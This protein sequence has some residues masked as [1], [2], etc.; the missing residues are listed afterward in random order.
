MKVKTSDL[1]GEAL[2][3]AVTL[4]D[5]GN[6]SIIM[7]HFGTF[8][9]YYRH[10]QHGSIVYPNYLNWS[11]AGP[12][13]EREITRMFKNLADGWTAQIRHEKEHP[14]LVGRKVTTGWTNA[15]GP[16]LLIATMRCFVQSRLGDEVEIPEE[17]MK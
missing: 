14:S 9:T 8:H 1:E 13:I 7:D 4:A 5:K 3:Y 11:D 2:N 15:S 17:L 12:I 6:A 16:T 10:D